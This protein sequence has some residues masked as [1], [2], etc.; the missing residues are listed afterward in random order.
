MMFEIL[1]MDIST[2]GKIHWLESVGSEINKVLSF[3]ERVSNERKSH[4]NFKE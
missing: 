3:I 2:D 1:R 4:L